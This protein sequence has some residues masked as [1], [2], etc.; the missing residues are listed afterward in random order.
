MS[1]TG[2]IHLGPFAFDHFTA[3][4]HYWRQAA[5]IDGSASNRSWVVSL[6]LTAAFPDCEYRPG[7]VLAV[8]QQNAIGPSTA[9]D[10]NYQRPL[11]P[12]IVAPMT[13]GGPC[14]CGNK[15]GELRRA[16][17]TKVATLITAESRSVKCLIFE[18][19]CAVCDLVYG[20][21]Y[22]YKRSKGGRG[23]RTERHHR[24]H[25]EFSKLR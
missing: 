22:I 1:L 14:P 4:V 2:T 3:A 24:H 11:L 16:K 5:S 8:M 25:H 6:M 10:K 15:W 17:W 12:R 19:C 9:P 23:R 18:R 20:A 7:Q 21:S 13:T